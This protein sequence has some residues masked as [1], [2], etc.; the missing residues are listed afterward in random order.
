MSGDTA[1]RRERA[2]DRAYGLRRDL[3]TQY[4]NFQQDRADQRL[5]TYQ[6]TSRDYFDFVNNVNNVPP[7]RSGFNQLAYAAGQGVAK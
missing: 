2:L 4:A 7:D 6:D 3:D 5:Q 1:D